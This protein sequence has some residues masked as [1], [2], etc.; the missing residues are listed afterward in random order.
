MLTQMLRTV[1]GQ[2]SKSKGYV[3]ALLFSRFLTASKDEPGPDDPPRPK[4][5]SYD[6]GPSF[7]NLGPLPPDELPSN[8]YAQSSWN[9]NNLV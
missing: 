1:L 5:A 4:Y 7:G 6:S 8:P 3:A 9:V 2:N